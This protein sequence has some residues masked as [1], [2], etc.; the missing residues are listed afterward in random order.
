[1]SPWVGFA[2]AMPTTTW[3]DEKS[4]KIQRVGIYESDNNI[5]L[6]YIVDTCLQSIS[7]LDDRISSLCST[8]RALSQPS[9]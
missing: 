4:S 1:M 2:H 6:S 5:I 3:Y 7:I 9:S 8:T